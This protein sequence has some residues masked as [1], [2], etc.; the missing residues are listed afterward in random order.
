[1]PVPP[2][3]A[4]ENRAFTLVE[5]I[6]AVALSALL[7]TIVYWTYFSINRSIEAAT[8][9]QDA[10]D[11]GRTLSELIKKDIRAI[12]P[13][14]YAFVGKNQDVGDRPF[15]EMEFVTNALLETDPLRLR[16]VGYMMVRTDKGE[17]ILVRRESKD[18]TDPLDNDP[19]DNLPKAFE[20]SR[21]LTGFV[22]EF[23]N[24]TD[25]VQTWDSG[26]SNTLPKQVRVTMEVADARGKKKTFVA[27]EDIQSAA[28]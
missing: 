7:L 14:Q 12:N 11:T 10:L 25:W 20:I 22:V 24:G 5:V 9:G 27:E 23:Y 3:G 15:G 4:G 17:M 18:L 13:A 2:R 6:L 28:Q 16:R 1:M 21:I 8:E 26:V 19:A